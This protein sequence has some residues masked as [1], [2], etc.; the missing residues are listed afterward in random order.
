MPGTPHSPLIF[1]LP[2]LQSPTWLCLW[3]CL[4][5]AL[6][7]SAS[8]RHSRLAPPCGHVLFVYVYVLAL[9]RQL[10]LKSNGSVIP[11]GR[12]HSSQPLESPALV[13]DGGDHDGDL[14]PSDHAGIYLPAWGLALHWGRP[15]G[16]RGKMRIGNWELYLPD[17]M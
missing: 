13:L 4:P 3:S 5:P 6:P 15:K 14:V 2:R 9:A 17:R 7:P 1:G 8:H 10:A 16:L 12:N 11:Q